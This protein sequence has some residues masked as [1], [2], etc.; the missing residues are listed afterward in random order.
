MRFSTCTRYIFFEIYN[1]ASHP[2]GHYWGYN[3]ILV[4]HHH[5]YLEW[6]CNLC[7]DQGHNGELCSKGL[8]AEF[9]HWFLIFTRTRIIFL[10]THSHITMND[11][12]WLHVVASV[13]ATRMTSPIEESE[14]VI[15]ANHFS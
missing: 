1:R 11:E 8:A 13:V 12:G 2:G 4:L 6:H 14:N 5:S 9:T 10:F 7:E 15:A 3:F